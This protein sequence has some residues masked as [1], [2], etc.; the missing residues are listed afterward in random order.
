MAYN[1]EALARANAL[2]SNKDEFEKYC[3]LAE[4]AG[5]KI[6]N[7]EDK[8]WFDQDLQAEPWFG[9]K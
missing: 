4:E 1:Y 5:E 3:K 9:I 7:K 6:V 8:K 2:A